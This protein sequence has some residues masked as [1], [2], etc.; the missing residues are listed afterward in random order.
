M[1]KLLDNFAEQLT[2]KVIFYSK[3][4][5]PEE[6]IKYGLQLLIGDV[7]KVLIILSI[8]YIIGVLNYC[9]ISIFFVGLLRSIVGGVHAS[10]WFNCLLFT[11]ILN[12]GATF[13][14]KYIT[15]NLNDQAAVLL[16]VISL[17]VFYIYAP[18]D[19]EIK[20][21]T[22]K[23]QI[24]VLKFLS[25]FLVLIYSILFFSLKVDWKNLILI[26]IIYNIICV[27]PVTYKLTN[28]KRSEK[29][30]SYEQVI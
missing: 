12:F 1:D 25:V 22:N 8:S 19:S 13:F 28:N 6:Q 18:S 14:V 4:E 27:L 5:S 10:S 9:L 2:K 23:N 11:S 17:I 15:Y 29:G 26:S 3:T 30:E 24:K 20:P 21:V 16:F 7:L